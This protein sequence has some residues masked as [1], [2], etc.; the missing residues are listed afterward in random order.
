MEIRQLKYFMEVA[1]REHMTE[2]ADALHVAQSAVSRQIGN[3]ESELGVDLFI[4]QGRRV[5]L[6]PIGRIFLENASQAMKMLENAT[7]E[8]KELLDPERG[9]IRIS[10]PISMAAYVLPT[11]ISAFR[12]QYPEAKFQLKQATYY[13]LIDLV[14]NGEYNMALLGSVPMNGEKLDGHVLFKERIMAL[15][16]IN[17]PLAHEPALRLSQLKDEPFILLP[18]GMQFREM[19]INHC[20][21]QGFEPTISFE[22]DD[23]DALKGLVSA[24][25]AFHFFQK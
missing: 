3:L 23:V 4:R 24:S 11:A 21:E 16:P 20:L 15:L 12:E 10:F 6:T 14:L 8:V 19:I 13:E 7:R 18:K 22:G 5:R 1:K 17:H 25:L 9:T 2:A